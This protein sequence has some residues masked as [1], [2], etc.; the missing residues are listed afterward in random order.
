MRSRPLRR[1][2]RQT[3]PPGVA[4]RTGV[5][6]QPVAFEKRLF[7]EITG[8]SAGDAFFYEFGTARYIAHICGGGRFR[9][10]D[11]FHI[12]NKT[13]F[14]SAVFV[15]QCVEITTEFKHGCCR[16]AGYMHTT[17]RE[18]ATFVLRDI[19]TQYGEA[20]RSVSVKSG[21]QRATASAGRT[22]DGR[23]AQTAAWAAR[24]RRLRRG[25]CMAGWARRAR[26]WQ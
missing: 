1:L 26:R 10:C 21:R 11:L 7:Q 23:W 3:A 8:R 15:H 20:R 6:R 22:G 17:A 25:S 14:T 16:M 2:R 5:C 12:R 4:S 24:A 18:T 9:F 19:G 13:S